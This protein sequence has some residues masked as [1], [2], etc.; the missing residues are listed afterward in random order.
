VSPLSRV[1][2]FDDG[3]MVVVGGGEMFLYTAQ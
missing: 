2:L 3:E 1:K